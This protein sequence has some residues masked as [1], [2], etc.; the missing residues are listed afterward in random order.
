MFNLNLINA[1]QS[2]LNS[3]YLKQDRVKKPNYCLINDRTIHYEIKFYKLKWILI[4]HSTIMLPNRKLALLMS[5][6]GR[7][8][9]SI[10]WSKSSFF[11]RWFPTCSLKARDEVNFIDLWLVL[12]GNFGAIF[13]VH[14]ILIYKSQC[15]IFVHN[16]HPSLVVDV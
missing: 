16:R 4:F 8:G 15:F 6:T 3:G 2:Q 11:F 1:N 13:L 12:M 14:N 9:L 7:V 5:K 10:N